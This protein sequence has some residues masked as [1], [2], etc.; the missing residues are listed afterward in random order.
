[1]SRVVSPV[2]ELAWVQNATSEKII[3]L[4]AL[5][6]GTQG[7]EAGFD[8]TNWF[9]RPGLGLNVRDF[10]V[11]GDGVTDDTTAIQAMLDGIPDPVGPYYVTQAVEFPPGAHVLSKPIILNKSGLSFTG[12]GVNN[13]SFVAGPTFAGPMFIEVPEYDP[14]PTVAGILGTGVSLKLDPTANPYQIN[15]R[16]APFCDFDGQAAITIE[17]FAKLDPSAVGHTGYFFRSCGALR[18][19]IAGDNAFFFTASDDGAGGFY[20]LFGLTLSSGVH[21]TACVAHLAPSTLYHL[22]LTYD[23]SNIR[24]FINGNLDTTIAA[25]GT[26]VQKFNEDICLG[27]SSS[28]WPQR[29]QIE[30][31]AGALDSV[32][33]DVTA[34]YT[35]SFTAPTAKLTCL[36]T[37]SLL[38]NFDTTYHMCTVGECAEL[39]SNPANRVQCYMPRKAGGELVFTSN[40]RGN[41]LGDFSLFC[42]FKTKPLYV[43]NAGNCTFKNINATEC[44]N[45]F[46][47]YLN[48]FESI[49]HNLQA[50]VQ[51]SINP[52]AAGPNTKGQYGFNFGISGLSSFDDCGVLGAAVGFVSNESSLFMKN[53]YYTS[54]LYSQIGLALFSSV[55]F[56]DGFNTDDE[57][58]GDVWQA[59]VL[60]DDCTQITFAGSTIDLGQSSTPAPCI[61][62]S[63]TGLSYPINL[64]T[65]IGCQF[66]PS[67]GSTV[68]K[69]TGGQPSPVQLIGCSQAG[70]YAG[71]PWGDSGGTPNLLNGGPSWPS[72]VQ[73][74]WG[75][76]GA[77][78]EA[79][80]PASVTT[81]DDTPVVLFE[82]AM[83]DLTALGIDLTVKAIDLD[84][85]DNRARWTLSADYGRNGGDATADTTPS[86]VGTGTNAGAVPSA[87]DCEFNVSTDTVQVLGTGDAS[88]RTKFVVISREITVT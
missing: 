45:G 49:F 30:P 14:V 40:L 58:P 84:D 25:T 28:Q 55:T 2:D 71:A 38:V 7:Q 59:G 22:A 26:I 60:I 8:G 83:A 85:A 41:T 56:I 81:T 12:S 75:P 5:P 51:G 62:V 54:N 48:C 61:E 1:M 37:T 79:D 64:L 50:T 15:C 43:A 18:H 44:A 67:S 65:F 86:V 21:G 63:S 77:Q 20:L 11:K 42:S 24:V 46:D 6:A 36:N 68:F 88:H 73:G 29:D 76:K 82:F 27:W 52:N 74:T 4:S 31:I 47:V 17:F 57:T 53:C 35:E 80:L 69:F 72:P 33:F 19:G 23:G 9:V 13:C 32:R 34:L 70:T 16:D 78:V 87:W 10:G 66:N 39:A 3:D